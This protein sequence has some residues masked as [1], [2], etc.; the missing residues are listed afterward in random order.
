M[1]RIREVAGSEGFEGLDSASAQINYL[2]HDDAVSLQEDLSIDAMRTLVQKYKD[3]GKPE[4]E[5]LKM[6]V[7]YNRGIFVAALHAKAVANAL[8]MKGDNITGDDVRKGFEQIKDFDLGGFLP[9]VEIT[10]TDH[11]GG[12]WVQVWQVRDGRWQL[13]RD[14][15][16]GYRDV[17]MDFVG[18]AEPPK[19][20]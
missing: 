1:L 16:Q 9:P 11:E 14:W 3:E 17:V 8:A 7:Y 2:V 20:Q 12:G 13:A 10:P 18:K 4:P 6:S 15:F 5:Q 19:A